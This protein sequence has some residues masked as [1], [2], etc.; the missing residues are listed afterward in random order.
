VDGVPR[1]VIGP[2]RT[3]IFFGSAVRRNGGDD[4][5]RTRDL[6]GD[7]VADCCNLVILNGADSPSLVL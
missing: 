5:T 4:G 6:C 2:K 3:E 7:R 1:R